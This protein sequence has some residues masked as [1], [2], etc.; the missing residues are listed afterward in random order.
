MLVGNLRVTALSPVSHELH[1]VLGTDRWHHN[2]NIDAAYQQQMQILMPRATWDC[3][4]ANCLARICCC[5]F[6]S[7][8]SF[9][10]GLVAEWRGA[11]S[12]SCTLDWLA[13]AAMCCKSAGVTRILQTTAVLQQKPLHSVNSYI[14]HVSVCVFVS[15][16]KTSCTL[17]VQACIDT[18]QRH[19]LHLC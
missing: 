18:S 3:C 13:C 2:Q 4:F 1:R 14:Q 6:T 8:I 15:R 12:C 5:D 9:A 17:A 11:L 10:V 16:L 19:Q 7:C